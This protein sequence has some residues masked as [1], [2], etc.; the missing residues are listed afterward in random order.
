M[1]PLPSRGWFAAWWL[2]LVAVLLPGTTLAELGPTPEPGSVLEASSR[3]HGPACTVVEELSWASDE[4]EPEDV[5]D[6]SEGLL[7][8]WTLE[9]SG[10]ASLGRDRCSQHR[11]HPTAPTLP[12]SARA[13]PR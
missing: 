6:G 11:L 12:Y 3:D 1:R 7:G 8:A 13:P 2:L 4:V 10:A 5:E 9:S